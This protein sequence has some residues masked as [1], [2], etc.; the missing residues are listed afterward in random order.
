MEPEITVIIIDDDLGSIQKLQNDLL[1]FSEIRILDTATTAELGKRHILKY[2]PDLVFLDVELPD[3]SGLD[4]LDDIRDDIL[5]NL[6]V[7]FYTVYDKYILDALRASAFDYLLKPYLIE[8]LEA[9]IERFH[10]TEPADVACMERSLRKILNRDSRFAI[11]TV[12]G[13]LLVRCE[14]IFLFQFLGDQR[15]WQIVLTSRTTHKLKMSTTAKD[16]L[17]IND[18]FVQI[19]QDCIVNLT[20]LMFI[21]NK[22]LRCEFYPPFQEEERI[23][24]HRYFKQLRERLDII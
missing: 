23:A 4:L 21:E 11:Q 6:R 14:E 19:S 22:T 13:L 10:T 24:S 12:S 15:C 2:H 1:A 20:Y 9:L 17:S 5:P 8:E 3:M 7:V 16:L 18:T